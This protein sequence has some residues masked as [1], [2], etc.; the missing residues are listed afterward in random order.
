MYL[1]MV[2]AC[3][4]MGM[5]AYKKHK[6]QSGEIYLSR[7][8]FEGRKTWHYIMVDKM[9]LPLLL[10]HAKIREIDLRDYGKI[11]FSGFGEEP[12]QE[13]VSYVKQKYSVH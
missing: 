12:P 13:L 10:K 3:D 6:A 5:P 11:L 4:V 7:G 2:K 1:N 8:Q 9:R